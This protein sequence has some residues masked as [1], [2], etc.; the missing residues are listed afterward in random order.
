MMPWS[1]RLEQRMRR[2]YLQGEPRWFIADACGVDKP[3]IA[4]RMKNQRFTMEERK[5][6]KENYQ[7]RRHQIKREEERG[8]YSYEN[9]TEEYRPTEAVLVERAIR[10]AI[11]P[12]DLT[13]EFFGDPKP[14]YSA[15]ER[16][17]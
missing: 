3:T 7:R 13:A 8:V 14:G 15:L 1:A 17:A 10:A 16:R 11:P 6:R 5:Q 4:N 9:R 12:R 2:L